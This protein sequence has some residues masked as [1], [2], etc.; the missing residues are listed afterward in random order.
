MRLLLLGMIRAY[1]RLIPPQRRRTCLFAKSCSRHVY[2]I[3]SADG[4]K[5]G[6]RAL[7]DRLRSCRPGFRLLRLRDHDGALLLSLADGRVVRLEELSD[8][9]RETV[10]NW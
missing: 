7:R 10:G 9:V 1:W 4:G 2:D 8:S 6:L 3:T 5:A